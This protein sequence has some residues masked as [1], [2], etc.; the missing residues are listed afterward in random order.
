[1][2]NFY[3]LLTVF[4]FLILVTGCQNDSNTSDDEVVTDSDSNESPSPQTI[5]DNQKI[6]GTLWGSDG[7]IGV[8]LSHGAVYDADSWEEQGKEMSE[9]GMI[10]FAVEDTSP[11]HLISAA[12]M[13]KE[14]Y[15]VDKVAL[16]GASAGGSTAIDAIT[17]HDFDFDRIVLLSPGGD[18]SELSNIPVL[19]IYS[20]DEGYDELDTLDSNVQTYSIPGSTHAQAMFEDEEEGG[21]IMDE[22]IQFLKE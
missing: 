11:D 8:V 13:L 15:D 1:M 20:E 5:N 17:E 21:Y 10:A 22:M 18:V 14:E 2:K 3:R 6:D 16:V 7:N 9:Q 12:N 19:V 4:A